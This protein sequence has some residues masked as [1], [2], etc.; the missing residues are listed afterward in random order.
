MNIILLL[1][2]ITLF[3][4]IFLYIILFI[5]RYN[6]YVILFCIGSIFQCIS[7]KPIV[8]WIDTNIYKYYKDTCD[9]IKHNIRETLLVKGNMTNTKQAI[10]VLH[11][12]GLISLVHAFHISTDITEWPYRNVKSVVHI[13]LQKIPFLLDFIS[14][15]EKVPS[16][17]F[18]M[19]S[20]LQNGDSISVALGN[21][22]EG[23]YTDDNRITAIVKT[24]KGIF[25]MAIETGIPLIPVISYGEQ[26]MFKQINSFGLLECLSKMIGFQLNV[27]NFASIKEWF[28]IY[29]KPLDKKIITCIGDPVEVGEARTPTSDDIDELRNKYMEALKQL[30]RDT[31]PSNYED[32]I[33]LI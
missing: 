1:Y 16:S 9:R 17:Y 25:K 2:P 18:A 12:H 10:Y 31:R 21:A 30:Y 14:E 33:V 5:F 4:Y 11:P 8:E 19:K 32:E 15:K 7:I 6:N 22:T 27:P 29:D 3:F 13:L 28:T 26:C 24:R 20:A 23:K